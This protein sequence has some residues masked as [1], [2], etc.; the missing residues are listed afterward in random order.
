MERV[1]IVGMDFYK[2]MKYS[3]FVSCTLVIISG[4][5]SLLISRGSLITT[6]ESIKGILFAAGSMGLITGAGSI[7]KKDRGK[8]KDW[9]EWKQRFHIF[10]FRV[11]FIIMSIVILLYGCI[12]DEILFVLNH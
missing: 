11:T 2:C 6:L 5:I 9:L 1:K 12:V 7:I 4:V 3:S 10:S 8:E